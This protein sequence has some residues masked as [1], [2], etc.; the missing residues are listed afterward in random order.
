M[1]ISIV[2]SAED[3]LSLR[4][5]WEALSKVQRSPLLEF[6]WHYNCAT[7]LHDNDAIHV[8]VQRDSDDVVNAI[9]PLVILDKGSGDWLEFLGVPRLI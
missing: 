3:M 7:T 1:T 8:L 5:D 6:G 2:D 9:A 4:D